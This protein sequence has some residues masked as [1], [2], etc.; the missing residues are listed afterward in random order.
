MFKYFLG[1]SNAGRLDK[2]NSANDGIDTTEKVESEEDCDNEKYKLEY[3]KI[4]YIK[5]K[6]E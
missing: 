6:V 5:N 3:P 2:E 4:L 1:L